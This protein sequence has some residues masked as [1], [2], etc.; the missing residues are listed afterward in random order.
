MRLR[1]VL[2]AVVFGLLA[3]PAAATAADTNPPRVNVFN[4]PEGSVNGATVMFNW[5]AIDDESTALTFVCTVDEAPLACA[6]GDG[7]L[8]GLAGG[9]HTLVVTAT[10]PSN[11]T[12]VVTR[13]FTVDGTPPETTIDAAQ[14]SP[15]GQTTFT[16]HASEPARGECRADGGAWSMCSTSVT[17]TDGPGTHTFEVRAIDMF[18]NVDSTPA[19][20]DYLVD[21][22]PPPVPVFTAGPAEQE[23]IFPNATLAWSSADADHYSC[24]L[25]WASEVDEHHPELMQH[26]TLFSDANCASP[27][28]LTG[29]TDGQY[30]FSVVAVGP[31][32]TPSRPAMRTFHVRAA[33]PYALPVAPAAPTPS[34]IKKVLTDSQT[35]FAR[36]LSGAGI[37]GLVKGTSLAFVAP[38]AGTVRVNATAPAA[39]AAAKGKKAGPVVVA[40]G[41]KTI[42]AA[43][44]TTVRV[45]VTKAGRKLLKRAHR[46]S[47]TL[48][49]SFTATGAKAPQTS[50]H[51]LTVK[52]KKR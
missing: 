52:R 7:S 12:A 44:A 1:P 41:T 22:G 51:K 17:R 14:S 25:E 29:L 24:V 49:T 36:T 27:R 40:S 6:P 19:R 10:D 4:P 38:T 31:G 23:V 39:H 28:T 13:H 33:G 21:A 42:R 37:E 8:T 47:L 20:R 45:K 50:S 32:G 11:N 35:A 3:A 15:G 9:E 26:K 30:Q 46:V 2:I 5:S 48:T 34:A 18:G 16:W 43:G